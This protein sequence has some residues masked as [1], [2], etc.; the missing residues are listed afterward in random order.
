MLGALAVIALVVG[1]I[2]ATVSVTESALHAGKQAHEPVAEAAAPEFER[3][4]QPHG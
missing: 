1:S 4:S 2:S 3:D